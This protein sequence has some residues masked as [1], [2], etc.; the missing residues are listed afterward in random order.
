[1]SLCRN[2]PNGRKRP[3]VKEVHPPQAALQLWEPLLVSL[4]AVDSS[5]PYQI[6]SRI[7]SVILSQP[8]D[9]V[10]P[11]TPGFDVAAGMKEHEKEVAS[12]RH[13]LATWMAWIWDQES[14]GFSLAEAQKRQ[15]G[16]RL[17]KGLV[18][19]DAT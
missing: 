8:A 10:P 5:L 13:A 14:S 4:H 12:Y 3:S 1:M 15:L 2:K 18:G 7:A 11:M 6:A 19:D 9:F 17:V 16:D